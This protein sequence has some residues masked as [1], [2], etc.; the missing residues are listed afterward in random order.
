[1]TTIS[2]GLRKTK[3]LKNQLTE[4]L[5]RAAGAVSHPEKNAPAFEFVASTLEA[6]KVRSSLVAL[7]TSIAI[8][9]ATTVVEL[10]ADLRA[11]LSLESDPVLAMAVRL[12]QELKGRIVWTKGLAVQ[13]RTSTTS[14]EPEYQ[15][16]A[17]GYRHVMVEKVTLCALP[18]P[19]KAALVNGLQDRFD[20]LNDAV[21]TTNHRTVLA[22]V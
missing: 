8:A 22:T 6:E 13:A 16:T 18:E 17:E 19:E 3:K 7:E 1:M 15:M 10:D 21:E 4:L 2:Q 5:A 20:R 12:L 14:S 9:N 11:V